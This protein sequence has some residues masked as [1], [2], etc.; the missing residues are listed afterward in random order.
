[1]KK[2]IHIIILSVLSLTTQAQT[3][4]EIRESVNDSIREAN[5]DRSITPDIIANRFD[6]V[7]NVLVAKTDT[8][9]SGIVVSYYYLDSMLANLTLDDTSTFQAVASKGN[10]FDGELQ[11]GELLINGSTDLGSGANDG[12]VVLLRILL[13][14][15]NG[16]HGFVDATVDSTNNSPGY[17]SFDGRPLFYGRN[18]NHYAWGQSR[19][20]IYGENGDT[21]DYFYDLV[22]FPTLYNLH[23]RRVPRIDIAEYTGNATSDTS[24]GVLIRE[25]YKALNNFAIRTLGN[26]P[27][28]FEGNVGI[29][30]RNG[31]KPQA[32]PI[33]AGTN[34]TLQ[35]NSYGSEVSNIHLSHDDKDFTIWFDGTNY[36]SYTDDA[37]FERHFSNS[38]ETYRITPEGKFAI[39]TTSP[40]SGYLLTVQGNIY[41]AGGTLRTEL[42][43]G[44]NVRNNSNGNLV[45]SIALNGDGST[46]ING[47][48]N[49]GASVIQFS[50]G[51]TSSYLNG[52]SNF[53]IGNNSPTSKVDI[54][55]SNGYTQFRL[56]NSYTP[57]STADANGNI[58]DIAWDD[59]YWYIKTS[60]G[61][62]RTA[63]S[64]Y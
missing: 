45:F 34:G 15:L 21:T 35:I 42:G 56:R 8:S 3:V 18:I 31:A 6:D 41:A 37:I 10:S 4:A 43:D 59:N 5:A 53:G 33:L 7:L 44:L 25:L 63:L 27:S 64:T 46:R 62:K 61:W 38:A 32:A 51:T 12:G 23:V 26:T 9:R 58:G 29:N 30:V 48:D 49:S 60:I 40:V 57:T 13:N 54:N 24:E 20:V 28:S 19:A 50:G 39:G 22:S 36:N 11:L 52:P 17:N 47:H 1:M 16:G 14:A 55:A 2:F